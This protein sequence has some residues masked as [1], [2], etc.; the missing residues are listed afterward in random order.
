[1]REH[2]VAA[3]LQLCRDGK[4]ETNRS[5]GDDNLKPRA[6]GLLIQA[7][8]PMVPRL[9]RTCPDVQAAVFKQDV[10]QAEITGFELRHFPR[11]TQ[12]RLTSAR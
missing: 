11:L 8:D 5:G 3:Q 1:M 12:D 6:L 4:V 9:H 2:G 10:Y 7:G